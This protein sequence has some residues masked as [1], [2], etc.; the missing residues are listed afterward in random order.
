MLLPFYFP[1]SPDESSGADSSI[2][3]CLITSISVFDHDFL[4]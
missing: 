2:L 1:F 3:Q 4:V